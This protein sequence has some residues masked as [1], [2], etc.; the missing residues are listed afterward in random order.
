LLQQVARR[1]E[2]MLRHTDL[3][4]PSGWSPEG[5]ENE[6][7]VARL[8][9]DEFTLWVSDIHRVEDVIKVAQRVLRAFSTP[10]RLR[11]EEIFITPSIGIAIYP[12]DGEDVESLLKNADA[13]MY[14]AKERGRNNYQFYSEKMNAAAS[15][16]LELENSLHRAI[17]RQEL[18]LHYQPQFDLASG[19]VAGV[20]ALLRWRLGGKE[21][22]Q[23]D[24][25]ISLAED[26][27]L[28][29]P[30]GEWALKEACRQLRDWEEAGLPV[31]R[32]AVNLSSR[33]FWNH[34]LSK[35]IANILRSTRL[36]PERL[37]LEITENIL[38][39]DTEGTVTLL[40]AL[41]NMGVG[42]AIDDFGSGYSSLN[43]LRRFP[44]DFLKID[45]CFIT[46]LEAEKGN[47]DIIAAITAMAHSLK[48]RVLA[49]GVETAAQLEY[50]RQVGCDEAQG[51][52][53]GK[54]LSPQDLAALLRS[55]PSI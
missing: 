41:K 54:P 7:V 52:L 34:K 1:L 44:V 29:V 20:E 33:Q 31:D 45:R 47:A 8:G 11:E 10:F 43:Y 40:R 14:Y 55:S 15:R 17:E 36:A 30:I 16:M 21:L 37:Q 24:Q 53:L 38:M 28:I 3:I 26:T 27:G 48:L 49:E 2:S 39:E 12:D 9:G 18:L 25:F 35:S 23:P 51:Y 13:A 4:A 32:V 42:F 5:G 22:L 6:R 46:Q 19:R 50:L